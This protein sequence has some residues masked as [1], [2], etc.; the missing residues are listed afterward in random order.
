M[1]D[2]GYRTYVADEIVTGEG[3]AVELPI[4]PVFG[5][6]LAGIIDTVVSAV[7]LFGGVYAVSVVTAFSSDMVIRTAMTLLVVA[8]L[9]AFPAAFETLTL[10]ATPGKL[11]LGQRVVRDDG[12]PI[13][14]RHAIVRALVGFVEKNPALM[15][16]PA[17][18]TSFVHPRAKRL[19]DMA[20]G[21]V[22]IQ[23]RANLRL[24]PPPGM[25]PALAGWAAGADVGTLPS[26]LSVAI[27][28]FLARAG[29]LAPASRNRIA[30]EL[31]AATLPHVSPAPPPAPAEHVLAA[32]IAER[33][34]RDAA[35][36][37]RES[38]LRARV[39][40]PDPL[41]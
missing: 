34:E 13:T 26:G 29:T 23:R 16:A 7:L 17:V 35:R 19:G 20:A 10:G 8:V 41:P 30:G 15:A 12:G 24:L 31:L 5:R 32:V 39:V 28:Q 18:V 21:T 11:A 14:G 27:R 37:A 9:V 2:P 38:R 6:I 33:R 1:S 25:P 36:L 3:V 4:T 22:V 40:P